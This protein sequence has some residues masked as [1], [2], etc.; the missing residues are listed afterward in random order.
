MKAIVLFSGGLDSRIACKIMQEQTEVEAIHFILPFAKDNSE[1]LKKFAAKEKFKLILINL[2][3]GKLFEEYIEMI[4]HPKH[5][6]GSALNPCRDCHIFMLKKAKEYADK[7]NI[8]IIATG[9]VLGSRPF[10]QTKLALNLIS[11]QAGFEILRPL[12]AK[13]LAE[14]SL[15][16]N[17]LV[18]RENLLAIK[19][20]KRTKQIELAKKYNISYPAPGGGCL[21][22]ER[23]YC[24]KLAKIIN[25]Q[26]SFREIKL[27]SIGRHFN[28]S[29]II[30]GRNQEENEIL[31][32]E[33]GIK[34]LP[35]V[36]APTALV[37]SEDLIEETKLLIQ[38]FSKN[39]I[40]KFE[41]IL[42]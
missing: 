29:K 37:Y 15:E 16:K 39:K 14:T 18:D 5:G 6:R 12:S 28:D 35:D 17:K 32:K 25:N 27:L 7:H 19:G 42:N 8:Q 21:L 1:E 38:K 30:L 26:I 3:D 11:K 23:K 24:D 31:E 4:K 33:K 9:E 22:C 20:R 36:P 41:I 10:S 13:L 2:R 34:I 40:N